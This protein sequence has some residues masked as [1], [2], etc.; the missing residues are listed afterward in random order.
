MLDHASIS[1]EGLKNKAAC[2]S[3][4]YLMVERRVWHENAA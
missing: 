3:D 2:S 4:V 1:A